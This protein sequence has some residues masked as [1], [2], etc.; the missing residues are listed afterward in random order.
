[1]PVLTSLPRAQ[2]AITSLLDGLALDPQPDT[3]IGQR[4]LS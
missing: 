4:R 2:S 3:G 1:M